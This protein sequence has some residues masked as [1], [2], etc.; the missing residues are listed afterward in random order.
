M[1]R[2]YERIV[3]HYGPGIIAKTNS[4]SDILVAKIQNY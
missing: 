1:L 4:R 2:L 3:K